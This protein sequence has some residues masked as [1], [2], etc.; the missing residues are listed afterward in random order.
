MA[1]WVQSGSEC[2][3]LMGLGPVG[4]QRE[5]TGPWTASPEKIQVPKVS[6]VSTR[7]LL[8]HHRVKEP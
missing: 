5:R 8:H 6:M 7:S 3:L 1:V 2:Q 4:P